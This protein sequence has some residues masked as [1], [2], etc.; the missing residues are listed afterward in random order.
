VRRARLRVKLPVGVVVKLVLVALA[1]SL[2]G[3]LAGCADGSTTKPPAPVALAILKATVTVSPKGYSGPC[4]APQNV[5]FAATFA[6]NPNNAG[7]TVHY[8]WTIDHTPSEA[9]V[10]FAPG[11]TSKTVTTTLA[12]PMPAGTPTE[13]HGS[14]ATTTPNAVTSDDAVVTLGCTVPFQITS[15]SV[16]MQPWSTGCGP[17]TFGWAA[18][19]TAPWNNTGG[20]VHYFWSF[21]A[22]SGAGGT[23][24]FTP[25]QVTQVVV[26]ARTYNVEPGGAGGGSFYPTVAPSQIFGRLSI[27]S[28]NAISDYASLDHYSC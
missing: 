20:S 1:L 21:A 17:H 19:I 27:D 10:T 18:V 15:V 13:L 4:G 16:T 26:A 7:G 24:T 6:A 14:I 9:D 2:V 25:G 22:A 8:V 3:V 12:Y 28:P 11:E 5:T 23:V